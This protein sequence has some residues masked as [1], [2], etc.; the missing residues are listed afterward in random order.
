MCCVRFLFGVYGRLWNSIASVP[1][2]YVLIYFLHD[3]NESFYGAL[4]VESYL[5]LCLR[6]C[7]VLFSIVGKGELVYEFL[8]H[9]FIYYACAIFCHFSLP[10]V[11]RDWL[12]L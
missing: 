7:L 9:L 1:D 2:R 4:R 3:Y 8:V 11:V 10:L 5:A 6:V 12:R